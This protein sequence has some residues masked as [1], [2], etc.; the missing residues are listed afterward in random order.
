[1]KMAQ[2]FSTAIFAILII[3]GLVPGQTQGATVTCQGKPVH[4]SRLGTEGDDY[5]IGTDGDDVIHGLGGDAQQEQAQSQ[6]PQV[7]A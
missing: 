3:G 7:P 2:G 1:M 6:N 5:L 4:P